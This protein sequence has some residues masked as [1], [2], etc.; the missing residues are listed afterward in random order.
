MVFVEKSFRP[1]LKVLIICWG[2]MMEKEMGEVWMVWKR[3]GR[4]EFKIEHPNK[5][6]DT[7]IFAPQISILGLSIQFPSE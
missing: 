3:K 1:G 6:V 5:I 2:A 4:T 7:D